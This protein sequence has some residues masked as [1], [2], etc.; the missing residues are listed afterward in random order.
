MT[1][2][3]ADTLRQI[4]AGNFSPDSAMENIKWRV[5]HGQ[6]TAEEYER[7]AAKFR[8]MGG[9]LPGEAAAVAPVEA[10]SVPVKIPPWELPLIG[11]YPKPPEL[12]PP[13][14]DPFAVE[15]GKATSDDLQ[16]MFAHF[17]TPRT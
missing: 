1:H 15:P 10:P 8:R 4:Q 2:P 6:I 5:E 12:Q 3:L 9:R 7:M 16:A 11:D 13:P 17:K 14:A